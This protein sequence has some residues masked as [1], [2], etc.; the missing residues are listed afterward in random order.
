MFS[1][2]SGA[3]CPSEKSV[4]SHGLDLSGWKPLTHTPIMIADELLQGLPAESS[5]KTEAYQ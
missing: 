2:H 3:Q 4:K 5:F 1:C